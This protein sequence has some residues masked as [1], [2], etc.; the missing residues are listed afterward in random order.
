MIAKE[1]TISETFKKQTRKAIFSIVVFIVT[2]FIL[3]VLALLLTIVCIFA[4][5]QIMVLKP[6]LITLGLG[7]GVIST[8]VLILIF[9]LKFLVKSHKVDRSNLVEISKEDEPKLFTLINQLV[10]QVGTIA[11]KKIYLS[12]DVNASVFYDSSFWSMFL[13]IQKNL[14]IGLGLVN[15]VT[16]QELKAILA[17]EFGHFSQKT[18]KVGSYTY[19]VNQI[20]FNLVNDDE[21][22]QEIVNRWGNS[23]WLIYFFVVI[24]LNIVKAIKWV[25]IKMYAFVN[26]RY[27]ALSREMEFQ[28]DEIAAMITGYQPLKTAL[29]RTNLADYSFTSVMNHY[30]NDAKEHLVSENI[31]PEQSFVLRFIATDSQLPIENNLPQ[32]PV[33]ELNRFNKSK[34]VIKDQWA[35]HPSTEERIN[36]LE[37]TNLRADSAVENLPA[38]QLFTQIE[39]WQKQFT[40]TIFE[41]RKNKDNFKVNSLPNFKEAYAHSF[42]KGTFPKIFNGYYDDKNPELKLPESDLPL[43]EQLD[44]KQAR[45][46]K[47]LFSDA[48]VDS[49]YTLIALQNDL[50]VIEQ[51]SDKKAGIPTF[52]YDGKKYNR[53]ESKALAEKV[54]AELALTSQQ[55][56][57]N[58]QQIYQYFLS[59]EAQQN[60]AP[61]LEKMYK[62]LS[63]YDAQID[64]DLAFYEKAMS[65]LEF[66]T[67]QLP[68]EQIKQYFEELEPL[69]YKI[70]NCIQKLCYNKDFKEMIQNGVKESFEQYLSK[71]WIYFGDQ[72]YNQEALD[73][74]IAALNNFAYVLSKGYFLYKKRLLDYKA[75]LLEGVK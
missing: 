73:V 70:K 35:S 53:K 57:Q 15:T 30:S 21:G 9:L 47:D 66:I 56:Q 13:P 61:Q 58:D 27:L 48:M 45:Q 54:A 23:S 24:A 52:D 36:R 51:I 1:I 60:K 59:I 29:L 4:G 19:N 74:L 62:T 43:S 32:V 5:I 72:V 42:T 26:K 40:H 68:P 63:D 37:K 38:N 7:I 69:E 10:E 49:V 6:S 12:A 34:L 16:Q 22:Y 55:I 50:Q 3:L 41:A 11:P 65:A 20:I 64:T 14:Q 71:T 28:A 75:V 39:L 67:V 17:H 18:M 33:S 2:Y 46:P 8:G 25:L 44:P 31:Y